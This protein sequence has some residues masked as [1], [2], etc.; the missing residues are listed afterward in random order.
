MLSPKKTGRKKMLT[1]LAIM[2]FMLFGTIFFIYKNYSLTKGSRVEGP[3][4]D[5]AEIF[6][7][8]INIDNIDLTNQEDE[9]KQKDVLEKQAEKDIDLENKKSDNYYDFLDDLK[10]INLKDNI[11]I[12][13]KIIVG[14]ENPFVPN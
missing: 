2:C 11:I 8:N 10:F 1:S 4:I 9:V 5:A 12:E 6:D 7:N 14:K 13:E 3:I